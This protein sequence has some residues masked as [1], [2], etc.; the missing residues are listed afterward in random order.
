MLNSFDWI[1]LSH[2]GTELL[3]TL[4]CLKEFIPKPDS[5]G[6]PHSAIDSPCLRCWIYPRLPDSEGIEHL[7]CQSC[8]LIID[9]SHGMVYN[10]RRMTVIWGFVNIL[11]R[12][13]RDEKAFNVNIIGSYI[14]DK[15][16]FLLVID[17][18][19][20]KP[21]TEEII[22]YNG[23][24]MRGLIQIFPTTGVSMG[25]MICR[26][27]HQEANRP[28]DKLR[29]RFHSTPRKLLTPHIFDQKGILTFDISDFL[30]LL[31]MATIFRVLLKPEEQ[32]MLHD[33]LSIKDPL[34][35][36]FYWGRFQGNLNQKTKDMLNSWK[37]REWTKERI[38]LLYEIVD[39]VTLPK[40]N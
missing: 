37:L 7:Y 39:Y 18:K 15:N 32:Q 16:H 5:L 12:Q 6:P 20:L 2:T 17:R 10:I 11:P 23:S 1:R 31:E 14:H 38:K 28:M 40:S 30:S 33:I 29:V 3:A 24:D 4:K 22:I 8:Q 19:Y 34:E 9:R 25:D 21:W 27:M 36:Q 13:L 35:E 26:A